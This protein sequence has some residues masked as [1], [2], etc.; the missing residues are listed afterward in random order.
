M[1]KSVTAILA[2]FLMTACV[3]TAMLGVGGVAFFNKA[4]VTPVN[5]QA[6][7]S[8]SSS[9]VLDNSAEIKQ[10]QDLVVQ[11]QSREQQYKQREQQYGDQLSAANNQLQA[12]QQ[13]LQQVQLLLM[14]LQQRGLI[15]ITNDGRVFI[16][17]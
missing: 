3:G 9:T 8:Q 1:K 7:I 11:Y 5:S 13:Q 15:T 10:L 16:N 12:A 6:Q 2:A 17:Q 14:A 4:G